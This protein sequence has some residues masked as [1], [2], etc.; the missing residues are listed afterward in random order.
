MPLTTQEWGAIIR[1]L[2][3]TPSPILLTGITGSLGGW[4]AKEA[5]SRGIPVLA[6]VRDASADGAR[7]RV[8]AALETAGAADFSRGVE[9]VLGDICQEGL[10]L[11]PSSRRAVAAAGAVVHCAASTEFDDSAREATAE[12]NVAGTRHVL[13]LAAQLRV[14]LAHVST[15]YVAGRRTGIALEGETDVGQAFNNVY[16]QTKCQAEVLVH[17]WAAET[18]LPAIVLRP[19]IVTGDRQGGRMVRLNTLHRLLRA[20][21][22]I[23]PHVGSGEFRVMADPGAT[24]NIVPVDTFADLAWRLIERGVPGAYHVTHPAPLRLGELRDIFA[25]L[26]N[27]PGLRL[28]GREDFARRPPTEA[29]QFYQAAAATYDPYMAAEPCFDRART[30]AALAGA[31]PAA[32]ELDA[33]FFGRLLAYG[34][35]TR[36]RSHLVPPKEGRAPAAGGIER[37]FSEFLAAKMNRPLLPDLRRLT[38]AFRIAVR[39][40]AG[41]PWFLSVERG[42]L[43][44]MARNGEAAACTFVTDPPTFREVVAGRLPP[45][46]AFF[47]RRIDVEGD[48][49]TGLKVAGVLAAFFRQFPYDTAKG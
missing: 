49:E 34:R 39:G 36:W 10:G 38:A 26:F 45:Q 2:I 8:A 12:V 32:P 40:V 24:K 33:A 5:L 46:K 9:I 16:E 25:A 7:R 41:R 20:F 14:P 13:A 4:L 37:Y 28:V 27:M 31:C 23:A 44:A 48:V 18:G 43:V 30:D 29:E 3:T 1:L 22:V 6:L 11:A 17:R 47:D 35:A 21:H 42:V 15:A 19:S